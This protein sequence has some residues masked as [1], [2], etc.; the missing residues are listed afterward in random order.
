MQTQR[1]YLWIRCACELIT[2]QDLQ[3]GW[4]ELKLGSA[5][6]HLLA[7]CWSFLSTHD[8]IGFIVDWEKKRKGHHE[9]LLFLLFES[10]YIYIS[11]S[12]YIA[13]KAAQLNTLQKFGFIGVNARNANVDFWRCGTIDLLVGS[14]GKAHVHTTAKHTILQ[15]AVQG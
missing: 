3:A 4:A 7:L 14:M 11:Y 5:C 10:H 15:S 1:K 8:I 13:I 12:Y 6:V 9:V 2:C